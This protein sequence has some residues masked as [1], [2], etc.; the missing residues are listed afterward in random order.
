MHQPQYIIEIVSGHT[1]I[2]EPHTAQN[3]AP[4]SFL[5]LLLPF[6]LPPTAAAC[7]ITVAGH[8]FGYTGAPQERTDAE[9]TA[10]ET[11]SFHH[12]TECSAHTARPQ[13]YRQMT[14]QTLQTLQGARVQQD[15]LPKRI[16]HVSCDGA[17]RASAVLCHSMLANMGA[18]ER[19]DGGCWG[20][21]YVSISISISISIYLCICM[22]MYVYIC[23]CM[24]IQAG[25]VFCPLP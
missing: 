1:I 3:S 24:Y 2:D 11:A 21:Y 17:A 13:T 10:P 15:K 8:N 22:Y 19:G 5:L 4:P 23:I 9:T 14:H 16:Q 18:T 12:V 20:M 7:T 25:V 6:P